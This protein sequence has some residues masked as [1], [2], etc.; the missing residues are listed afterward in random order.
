MKQ[1]AATVS[2]IILFL[3]CIDACKKEASFETGIGTGGDAIGS[4]VDSSGNCREIIV[5]GTYKV[6]SIF[7]DS[8]YLVIKLNISSRGKYKVSTDSSN[9]FWFIDSGYILTP[10]I[11]T[12][13]VKGH[14]KPLLPLITPK[15]VTF[16]SSSC[17]ININC[18]VLPLTSNNDYFPTT[19]GSNWAYYYGT[20]LQ[21]TSNTSVSNLYGIIGLNAY[22]IFVSSYQGLNDT[23]FYRKDVSGNYYQYVSLLDTSSGPID[24]PFLKDYK[25]VNDTWET[26]SV[27]GILNGQAVTVKYKFTMLAKNQPYTFNSINYTDV[28]KIK[29]EAFIKSAFVSTYPT[30]AVFTDY[31][32]YAR[33]IGWVASEYPASPTDN[34]TLKRKPTIK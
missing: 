6:D 8:N 18:G 5:K 11:Q 30:T 12:V 25:S 16:D 14:G 20:N 33:N 27:R 9:G 26:D 34:V 17:V 10:G 24:Y 13:K 28:I 15:V 1:F 29:E 23:T 2:V 3:F 7:T 32:Y 31:S 21:D 22:S 4:I 19:V